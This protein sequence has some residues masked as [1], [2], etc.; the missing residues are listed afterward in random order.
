MLVHL[1]HDVGELFLEVKLARRVVD[2]GDQ[3]LENNKKKKK[4]AHNLFDCILSQLST[5]HTTARSNFIYWKCETYRD[6]KY[7]WCRVAVH[8]CSFNCVFGVLFFE[9]GAGQI[10]Q[11]RPG[12]AG[13]E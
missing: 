13:T 5:C 4:K 6:G 8:D 11:S 10:R 12:M 1:H 7:L 2:V 9:G 3:Q